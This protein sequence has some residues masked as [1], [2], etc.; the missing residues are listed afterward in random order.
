MAPFCGW[1]QLPEGYTEPLRGDSLPFSWYSLN[2]SW[3][4]EMLR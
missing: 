3:E 2:Q 4:D 1:A